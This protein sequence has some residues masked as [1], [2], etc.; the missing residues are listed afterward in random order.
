M[1]FDVLTSLPQKTRKSRNALRNTKPEC[2]TR[3]TTATPV[4]DAFSIETLTFPPL[5]SSPSL[6]GYRY[7]LSAN[8]TCLHNKGSY[9]RFV[10]APLTRNGLKAC[11]SSVE[12]EQAMLAENDDGIQH[13]CESGASIPITLRECLIFRLVAPRL[14]AGSSFYQYKSEAVGVWR[15]ER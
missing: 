9:P 12:A 8:V 2:F 13:I 6:F 14:I 10:L 15:S 5:S 7:I 3:K 11:R 4:K 1:H